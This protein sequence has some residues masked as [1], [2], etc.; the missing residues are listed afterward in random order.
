MVAATIASLAV[1]PG[2]PPGIPRLVSRYADHIRA[3]FSRF[4]YKGMHRRRIANAGS[5]TLTNRGGMAS[6]VSAIAINCIGSEREA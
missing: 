3:G 4:H 6:R 5:H 1:F 2:A